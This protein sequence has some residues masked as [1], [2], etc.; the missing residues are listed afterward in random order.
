MRCCGSGS[1][2]AGAQHEWRPRRRAAAATR[3]RSRMCSGRRTT[4]CARPLGAAQGRNSGTARPGRRPVFAPCSVRSGRNARHTPAM[5]TFA[6]LVPRGSTL[7][8]LACEWYSCLARALVTRATCLRPTRW[9]SPRRRATQRRRAT[10]RCSRSCCRPAQ[11]WTRRRVVSLMAP[12]QREVRHRRRAP[13]PR[14][15]L[16]PRCRASRPAARTWR[17][18]A[19]RTT[20]AC[21]AC[22]EA[23]SP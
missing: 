10:R 13:S 5:R 15:R 16:R 8:G 3:G 20:S 2:R 14:P 7:A 6:R 18:C 19:E 9:R 12:P 1:E 11:S 23:A 21:G 22:A 17:A 4:W